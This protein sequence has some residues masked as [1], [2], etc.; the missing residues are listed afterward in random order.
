MCDG[1][2]KPVVCKVVNVFFFLSKQ[3]FFDYILFQCYFIFYL[4]P[5]DFH[6]FITAMIPLFYNQQQT[7]FLFALWLGCLLYDSWECQAQVGQQKRA[8]SLGLTVNLSVYVHLS[9]VLLLGFSFFV[10]KKK[11]CYVPLSLTLFEVY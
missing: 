7:G 9:C 3:M 5:F 2:S 10:F 8:I 11:I 6:V 4:S 1:I